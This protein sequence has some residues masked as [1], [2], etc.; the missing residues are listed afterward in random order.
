MDD[1]DRLGN[2]EGMNV[3]AVPEILVPFVFF[4][5]TIDRCVL[6]RHQNV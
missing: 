1:L 3:T 4:F 5:L 2:V 6:S